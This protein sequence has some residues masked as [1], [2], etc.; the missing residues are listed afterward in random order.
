[1]PETSG[2]KVGAPI[3]PTRM[4]SAPASTFAFA[5][6]SQTSFCC[7]RQNASAIDTAPASPISSKSAQTVLASLR[8]H[9]SRETSFPSGVAAVYSSS[10]MFPKT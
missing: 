6:A 7:A 1:M 2:A 3:P 5:T 8:R 4:V 10:P 9:A